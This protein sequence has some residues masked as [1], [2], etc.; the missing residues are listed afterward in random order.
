METMQRQIAVSLD[1]LPSDGA[2]R[3]RQIAAGHNA[4]ITFLPEADKWQS[5]PEA[6][7][8]ALGLPPA[9]V[10]ERS[11]LRFVQLH[12]TGFD[13]YCT[14]SLLNRGNF[15]IANARGVMAQA[16][17]EHCLSMMFA[18]SRRVQEYVRSQSRGVWQRSATYEVLSGSTISIVG[19]GAIGSALGV[20]CKGIGMRVLAVQRR[21]ER[22]AWADAVFPLEQCCEA[23]RQSR[24]LALTLPAL[25]GPPLLGAPELRCMPAG[26]YVYNVGRAATL[27]YV[28]LL[29]GLTTGTIA[30]AGLDVFPEEPLPH[31]HP[32][33]SLPNV[34]VSPHVGGRFLAEPGMLAELFADNL[35]RYLEGSALRNV[36]IGSELPGA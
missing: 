17:A 14:P 16:V 4:A 32:F 12:S 19:T 6:T 2:D 29:E 5:L 28:A 22:P 18:L 27:D 25:P 20:M 13:T 23:L 35:Q 8:A 10:I 11:S 30:G 15:A 31:E 34:L 1:A 21:V 3:L 26:G 9:A 36:V 24:H 33:W 7:E